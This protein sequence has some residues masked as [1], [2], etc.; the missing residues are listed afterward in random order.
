MISL[1]FSLLSASEHICKVQYIE[2]MEKGTVKWIKEDIIYTVVLTDSLSQVTTPNQKTYMLHQQY[3]ADTYFGGKGKYTSSL[4]RKKNDKV[5]IF[6]YA[7]DKIVLDCQVKYNK[8]LE[9]K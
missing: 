6:G 5:L 3:N 2:D 1:T 9:E 7:N 4:V 8:T